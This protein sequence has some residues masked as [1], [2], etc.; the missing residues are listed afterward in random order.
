MSGAGW[1]ASAGY[2]QAQAAWRGLD[3]STHQGLA[4]E[5]TT[6]EELTTVAL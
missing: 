5:L 3:Q 4:I 1:V 6:P 2:W